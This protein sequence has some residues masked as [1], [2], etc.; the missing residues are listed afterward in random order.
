MAAYE[1]MEGENP[2]ATHWQLP[3]SDCWYFIYPGRRTGN[4]TLHKRREHGIFV[5]Y[6]EDSPSC[7]VRNPRRRITYARWFRD[8]VFTKPS[9]SEIL[10]FSIGD[11][12]TDD[13]PIPGVIDQDEDDPSAHRDHPAGASDNE[14]QQAGL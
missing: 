10:E 3:L 7:N 11:P 12:A 8:V 13:E 14:E 1:A 6:N 4:R 9:S 2:D 5:G